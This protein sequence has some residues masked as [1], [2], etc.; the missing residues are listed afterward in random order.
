[1]DYVINLTWDDEDCNG[2]ATDN[3]NPGLII[4]SNTCNNLIERIQSAAPKLLSLDTSSKL[5]VS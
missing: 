1:M 3:D 2:V 5:S 4:E